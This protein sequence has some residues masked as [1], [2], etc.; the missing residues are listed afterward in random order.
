[1]FSV[2]LH[3][4][5]RGKAAAANDPRVLNFRVFSV[6]IDRTADVFPAWATPA[7]G[8]YALE[9]VDADLFRWVGGEATVELCPARPDFL[10]FDAEAGPGML[11]RPFRLRVLGRDGV[12][13]VCVKIGSRNRV[14]VPL[15]EADGSDSISFRAEGGGASVAGDPRTLNFRVFAPR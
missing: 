12:E 8:F 3:A 7:N 2:A 6:S 1:M 10:E 14:T 4:G 9:R 15:R 11:S 13:L 5:R